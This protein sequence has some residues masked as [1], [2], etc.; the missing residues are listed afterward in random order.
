MQRRDDAAAILSLLELD[1]D[2]DTILTKQDSL[3]LMP[4]PCASGANTRALFS[5]K[6]AS[7]GVRKACDGVRS[8]KTAQL[9]RQV[10]ALVRQVEALRRTLAKVT[11]TSTAAQMKSHEIA[12]HAIA[13]AIEALRFAAS[14]QINEGD[15]RDLAALADAYLHAERPLEA[16][17]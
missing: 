7:D 9:P 14:R 10:S 13:K 17:L 4:G 1:E 6:R 15:K 11:M 2:Y 5:L 16:E 8:S 3:C 12:R